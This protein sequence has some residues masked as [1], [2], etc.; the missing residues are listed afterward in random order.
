MPLQFLKKRHRLSRQ[1]HN[2]GV[3]HLHPLGRDTPLSLIQVNFLPFGTPQLD[4]PDEGE[5]KQLK[6]QFRLTG[7][8]IGVQLPQVFGYLVGFE[9]GVVFSYRRF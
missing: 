7:A 8:I 6:S 3:A 9:I 2:V 5:K 4:C 1:R